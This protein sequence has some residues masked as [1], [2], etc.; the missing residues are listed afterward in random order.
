MNHIAYRERIPFHINDI[1]CWTGSEDEVGPCTSGTPMGLARPVGKASSHV[2]A[3]PS[4]GSSRWAL[5]ILGDFLGCIN[6]RTPL[7]LDTQ[8]AGSHV[9]CSAPMDLAQEPA[10]PGKHYCS[11]LRHAV[12]EAVV[13]EFRHTVCPRLLITRH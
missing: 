7:V 4:C 11:A 2:G 9:P 1:C 8:S 5:G 3:W 13:W 10:W 6:W 12:G